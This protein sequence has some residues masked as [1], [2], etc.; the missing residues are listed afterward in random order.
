MLLNSKSREISHPSD[1]SMLG[2]CLHF[3][4]NYIF[5]TFL[6]P[7][8]VHAPRRAPVEQDSDPE[9]TAVTSQ[10]MKQRNVGYR[11]LG[12]TGSHGPLVPQHARAEINFV[13]G[14]TPVPTSKT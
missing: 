4:V 1:I 3:R 7:I 12:Q 10:I 8:G 6:G 11:V 5:V 9:L 13:F 2:L 14:F